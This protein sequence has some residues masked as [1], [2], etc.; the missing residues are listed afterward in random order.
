M[1]WSTES[2]IHVAKLF[3]QYTIRGRLLKLIDKTIDKDDKSDLEG[4]YWWKRMVAMD[5]RGNGLI[6]GN[7]PK[8]RQLVHHFL[9]QSIGTNHV[10]Q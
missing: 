6:N 2:S 4:S 8:T 3:F 5:T 7:P 9:R 1:I 10:N